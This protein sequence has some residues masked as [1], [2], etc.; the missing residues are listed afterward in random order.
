M[1]QNHVHVK[2]LSSV[3]FI[4][5]VNSMT[6]NIIIFLILGIFSSQAFSHGGGLNKEGCHNDRKNGG[7]HCH[8]SSG[9]QN[10]KA[11]TKQ[12]TNNLTSENDFNEA[13]ARYL[14]GETEVRLNYIT[15]DNVNG[16][17]LIDIVTND[18]VIEGGLDKRSSLDSLQ[19]AIFA[20]ILTGKMP[21]IALYD[22]DQ[23]IGKYE[24]R[25]IEASRSVGVTI[26]WISEGKVT[27]IQPN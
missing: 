17:V 24:H 27:K 10:T 6:F 16:Y 3:W 7:Y 1:L 8:R 9:N 5:A 23:K 15:R 20:S 13:F 12:S 25:I 18:Y 4:K 21:A 26:F 19:Q 22:T 11:D 14:G 2:S